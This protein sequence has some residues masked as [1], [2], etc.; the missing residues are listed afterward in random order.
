MVPWVE[1]PAIDVDLDVPVERRYDNV[2]QREIDRGA[3]LLRLIMV[4][5]PS[6]AG[7]IAD[8]ARLRTLGR[9]H[10]EVR[11]IAKRVNVDW[12]LVM[13]ANLTY[14]LVLS[15]F[16][17]STL[18][19]A[20]PSGPVLARN[21]DFWPENALAQTSALVRMRR[22]GVIVLA[23]AG[24]PGAVGVVTGMSSRGVAVAL[25]A[26]SGPEG[27]RWTG[28]PVLL[29]IR[30]VLE[31][32]RDFGEAVE[33][34]RTQTL[35]A[36]CLLTVVGTENDQRVVIERSP[37]KSAIRSPDGDSALIAT[38]DY[39]MLFATKASDE[40]EIYRTTCH[41]YDKLQ[42]FFADQHGERDYDDEALLYRLTDP[43]VLQEITAQHVVMRPRTG[44][45]RMYV[46]R[47]YVPH[48]F[49]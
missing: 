47:R 48:G 11:S 22:G 6:G 21:M 26:V 30:R 34:F 43:G 42:Q 23:N 37:T 25:N 49:S 24:W 40:N 5:L 17:C 14:D 12:R 7:F 8:A 2:P 9:F 16:G 41:R 45:I 4:E 46:P 32:A 29:F 39:R 13:L 28:Y 18:A 44:T 35:A 20:T 15:Q 1:C 27:V 36:S 19:L 31:D 33:L 3:R 10:A 38:N